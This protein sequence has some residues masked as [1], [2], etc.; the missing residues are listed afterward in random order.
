MIGALLRTVSP[1]GWVTILAAVLA[2]LLGVQSVR[3]KSAHADLLQARLALVNPDTGV[4]WSKEASDLRKA[5]ERQNL[6]LD[7]LQRES[8]GKI[9][10]SKQAASVAISQAHSAQRAAEALLRRKPSGA[11]SCERAV[12]QQRAFLEAV[13]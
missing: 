5:I 12:D 13:K 9:A 11:T 4:K 8:E 7:A 2:A 3:L 6:A 1:L 10:Q